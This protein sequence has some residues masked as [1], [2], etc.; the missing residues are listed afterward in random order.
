MHAKTEITIEN[1]VATAGINQE[2]N[3]KKTIK[4][5]SDVKYNPKKFPGAIIKLQS[6]KAT[7]LLFRTG[8]IVCTGTKSEENAKDALEF[9]VAKLEESGIDLIHGLSDVKI[10]NIASSCNLKSE[11]HLEKAAKMLPRSLY[12]PEQFSGIILRIPYPKTVI[13]LFASGKL[14]C[15]GAKVTSDIHL[16]VNTLHSMLEEKNLLKLKNNDD[17]V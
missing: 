15:T 11:I 1:V 9:F 8:N 10:Q 14:V 13:L 16:S 3:I 4:T 6:P 17:P 7:I 2:I 12:E 5:F